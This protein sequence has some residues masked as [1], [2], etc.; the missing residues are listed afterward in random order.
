MQIKLDHQ[1]WIIENDKAELIKNLL[2]ETGI[3]EEKISKIWKIGFSEKKN[4]KFIEQKNWDKIQTFTPTENAAINKQLEENNI[5]FFKEPIV[6]NPAN[7][8]EILHSTQPG[9]YT[10]LDTIK[11]DTNGWFMYAEDVSILKNAIQKALSG[12]YPSGAIAG[13]GI[14]KKGTIKIALINDISKEKTLTK[15]ENNKV[16]EAAKGLYAI[17]KNTKS[18]NKEVYKNFFTYLY[19]QIDKVISEIK[20][21]VYLSK[22][23]VTI[24]IDANNIIAHT[25][26]QDCSVP[27]INKEIIESAE[28]ENEYDLDNWLES[29]INS[30]SNQINAAMKNTFIQIQKN[31]VIQDI[32]NEI[33]QSI[34]STISKKHFKNQETELFFDNNLSQTKKNSAIQIKVKS[35]NIAFQTTIPIT[36]QKL[37]NIY[38]KFICENIE[39]EDYRNINI[40]L[41]KEDLNTIQAGIFD[42]IE[43]TVNDKKPF[44]AISPDQVKKALPEKIKKHI[45]SYENKE[46]AIPCWLNQTVQEE[47]MAILYP[48]NEI[49]FANRFFSEKSNS[50]EKLI[51]TEYGKSIRALKEAPLKATLNTAKKLNE[52]IKKLNLTVDVHKTKK[53]KQSN[54]I[55]CSI[56]LKDNTSSKS[57]YDNFVQEIG[58]ADRNEENNNKIS[59]LIEEIQADRKST[60]D[61]VQS[62]ANNI[63]YIAVA[64]IIFLNKGSS[65]SAITANLR[66]SNTSKYRFYMKNNV[67]TDKL[68]LIDK[69]ELENTINKLEHLEAINSHSKKGEYGRFDV[70]YPNNI[71]S[72]AHAFWEA[73][74]DKILKKNNIIL[75][76]LI[77]KL[78]KTIE[79]GKAEIFT[80]HDF[81]P[82]IDDKINII[83]YSINLEALKGVFRYAPD[84]IIKLMNMKKKLI[85]DPVRIKVYNA[86]IKTQKEFKEILKAADFK[87]EETENTSE[88]FPPMQQNSAQENHNNGEPDDSQKEIQQF[89]GDESDG[90]KLLG[91]IN[92]GKHIVIADPL[93]NP[94]A[95]NLTVKIDNLVPGI[96][97]AFI[98]EIDTGTMGIRE[99]ALTI[100]HKDYTY[101]Q[102]NELLKKI[103]IDTATVGIYDRNFRMAVKPKNSEWYP[104][105]SECAYQ[106]KLPNDKAVA[107]QTGFGDGEYPVFVKHD[108]IGQIYAI[109]IRFI[110]D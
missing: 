92:L 2:R 13:I 46:K 51:E 22:K 93:Y 97:N 53:A 52:K 83:D 50:S 60:D 27:F 61:L 69:E 104:F 55:S 100:I 34:N 26:F 71:T 6:R 48:P 4:I 77:E 7:N 105:I 28:K 20:N 15:K 37:Q 5:S 85:N 91:H 8:R 1:R 68:H 109:A 43:Q 23:T 29:H 44:N 47:T 94:D 42:L 14:D 81:L 10:F 36:K 67:F 45:L 58:S 107:C 63:L 31:A 40:Y 39:E 76:G 73:N 87:P 41:K 66:G 89:H 86:L 72:A 21:K 108:K 17:H 110:E 96:Y 65:K 56:R 90:I 18:E 19:P 79:E 78:S 54:S 106:Q 33:F 95:D 3:S 84:D 82:L 103:P 49:V 24:S 88:N 11:K 80:I 12:K 16:K 38:E 32:I 35:K 99:A 75:K 70:Y 25:R 57:C 62:I 9:N 74:M 102:P 64:D 98:K 59:A 101:E 30:I